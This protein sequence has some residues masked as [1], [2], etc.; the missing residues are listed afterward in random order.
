MDVAL[1]AEAAFY[2]VLDGYT[3]ADLLAT[4][5]LDLIQLGGSRAVAHH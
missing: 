3:V 5:R 4:N 2:D 1:R